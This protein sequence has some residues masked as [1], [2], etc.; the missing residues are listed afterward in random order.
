MRKFVCLLICIVLCISLPSCAD[1]TVKLTQQNIQDYVWIDISY[2]E[3]EVTDAGS[4]LLYAEYYYVTCT[5][6]I[7]IRPRGDYSFAD[8]SCYYELPFVP[9]YSSRIDCWRL[10]D[11]QNRHIKLDKDGYGEK[12]VYLYRYS[13][14][15]KKEYP[16]TTVSVDKAEGTVTIK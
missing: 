3:W 4:S 2:S 1:K 8:A 7:S 9:D 16:S 13:S 6:T 14:K 12:V 5:A 10:S 15:D 11:G